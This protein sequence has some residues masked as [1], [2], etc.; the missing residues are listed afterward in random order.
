MET[1]LISASACVVCMDF[2][3]WTGNVKSNL[4]MNPTQLSQSKTNTLFSQKTTG[5]NT[6]AFQVHM[7]L[8]VLIKYEYCWFIWPKQWNPLKCGRH[9]SVHGCVEFAVGLS[10]SK[11]CRSH[12]F[13]STW[14]YRCECKFSEET[15]FILKTCRLF[16]LTTTLGP[17]RDTRLHLES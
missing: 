1:C 5:K 15:M 4:W 7:A 17:W 10:V 9:A 6:N 16:C 2:L 14:D 12:N 3:P 11:W 8:A 13:H